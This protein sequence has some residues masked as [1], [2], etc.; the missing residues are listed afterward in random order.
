VIFLPSVLLPSVL[1]I[2]TCHTLGSRT[3]IAASSRRSK[4]RE[5]FLLIIR[6][7]P[8]SIVIAFLANE[9]PLPLG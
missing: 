4:R 5:M 7:F 6:R 2:L 1:T 8:L 9:P 3:G